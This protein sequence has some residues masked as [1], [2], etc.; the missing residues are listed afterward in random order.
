MKIEILGCSGA[1][2]INLRPTAFLINNEL[3]LDAG[4]VTEVLTPEQCL[5]IKN[6]LLTHAHLDHIGGLAYL[7]DA[8]YEI[9]ESPFQIYGLGETLRAVKKYI[10]N[11]VVWP[12]FAEIPDFSNAKISYNPIKELRELHVDGYTVTP[13]KV[14][15]TVPTVGYIIDDGESALAFSSDTSSTELIWQKVRDA[16]R[17]KA[18]ILEASFPNRYRDAAVMSG[19]LTP[20]LLKEELAKLGRDEEVQVYAT[21]IKPVHREEVIGEL[22]ELSSN[23]VPVKVLK[24]GMVLNI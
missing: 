15:H 18:V 24:D 23:A 11:N 3:L 4:T 21:H 1:P 10:F 14:N 6:I 17:L 7:P 12:D 9:L 8:V 2:G 16:D 5:G 22:S 19:H 13:V 20:A